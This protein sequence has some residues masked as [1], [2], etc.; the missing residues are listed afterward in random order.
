M[1]RH[2]D[3]TLIKV[4]NNSIRGCFDVSTHAQAALFDITTTQPA[5]MLVTDV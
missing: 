4:S 3:G 2:P 1:G 5:Y